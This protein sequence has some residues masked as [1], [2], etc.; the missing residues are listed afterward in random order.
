ALVA[1]EFIAYYCSPA[2]EAPQTVKAKKA[3][4]IDANKDGKIEDDECVAFWVA[5]TSDMD[6][7]KDGKVTMD[8]FLAAAKKEFKAIDKNGDGVISVQELDYY[9][10]PQKVKAKK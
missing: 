6:L 9:Y 3:K 5:Q 1:Q 10:A 4:K 2:A 8:E 7:N